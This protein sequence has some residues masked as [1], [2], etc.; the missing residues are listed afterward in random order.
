MPSL[1]AA[2]A[3]VWKHVRKYVIVAALIAGAAGLLYAGVKIGDTMHVDT[4]V[5]QLGFEDIGE[6]AT[7]SAIVTEVNNIENPRTFFG[8]TIP[9]TTTKLIYSY[10][11]T[12]KAGYDFDQISYKVDED[13]KKV[14][15]TMPEVRVLSNELDMDSFKAYYEDQNIF[16]PFTLEKQNEALK[17]LKQTAEQ[18]AIDNG[19]LENAQINGEGLV[20][21][22]LGS[23]YSPDE[24]EYVFK[25]Q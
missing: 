21:A 5:T 19:L 1:K 25:T 7:Q 22:F 11:A 6:L 4:Q 24:Y 18:T 20:K 8:V 13:K 12:V 17:E 9:F 2:G 16:S 3:S 10:T 15:V 14:T 23:Q